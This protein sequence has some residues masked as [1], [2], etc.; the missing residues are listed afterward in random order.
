ME[1]KNTVA[2]DFPNYGIPHE[3]NL[4]LIGLTLSSRK[5]EH[6]I[7]ISVNVEP[8]TYVKTLGPES[9]AL[10]ADSLRSLWEFVD[11]LGLGYKK[12]TAAVHLLGKVYKIT[13]LCYG[14]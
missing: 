3:A 9:A 1:V 2:Y 8:D 4:N 5:V 13:F 6:Q 14:D 12:V 11:S 7:P 10:Y